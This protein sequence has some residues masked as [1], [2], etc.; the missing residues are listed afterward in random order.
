MTSPTQ[1]KYLDA[2]GIPVWVSRDIVVTLDASQS[3]STSDSPDAL[4]KQAQPSSGADSVE[5]ILQS[6]N[7]PSESTVQSRPAPPVEVPPTQSHSPQKATV[8]TSTP[9]QNEVARTTSHIVYACGS[10]QAD[11]MIIGESPELNDDRTN[12]P[13]SGD[14]GILLENMLRAVGLENPRNDAY[15]INV[16]KASMQAIEPES[17]GELNQILNNKIKEVKPKMILIVGQLSAQNVLQSKEPLARLRAKAQ[18]HPETGTNIVVTYYPTHLLS[19]PIDKRK[20][21]DD[22]KL[23]MRLIDDASDAPSE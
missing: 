4:S 16:I 19:K 18:K 11:W 5:S 20:A 21:W 3:S 17:I 7:Q 15:M 9:T 8:N 1:L 23:A 10:L 12:Q 13:Y 22:L 14:S 2:I 6:L